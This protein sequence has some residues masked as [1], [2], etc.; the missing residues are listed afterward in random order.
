MKYFILLSFFLVYC[1]F[2]LELGYSATLPV[3]KH[4]TYMFQHASLM[5]LLINSFSFFVFFSALIRHY[6]PWRIAL[7]SFSVG[8]AASF[9]CTY[10]QVVVGASGVIYAMIGMYFFLV[11]IGRVRFQNKT[12]L[13]VSIVSVL[14]FLTISFL[15]HNSAGMLH[16]LCLLSGYLGSFLLSLLSPKH[17]TIN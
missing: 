6:P 2:G 3:W 15:K 10:S 4:I 7:L 1:F 8:F 16:L 11:T 9:F 13:I 14:T 17:Q 12:S 5:H